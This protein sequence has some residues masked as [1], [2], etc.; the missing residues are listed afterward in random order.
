[1][2]FQQEPQDQPHSLH[3][4][5]SRAIADQSA[6]VVGVCRN[7]SKL[8]LQAIIGSAEE[9]TDLTFDKSRRILYASTKSNVEVT[10]VNNNCER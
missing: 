6:K 2:V 9:I 4:V 3:A 7:C 1:M 5:V 10:N 8:F